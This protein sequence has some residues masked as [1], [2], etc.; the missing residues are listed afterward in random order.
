MNI[1][2]YFIEKGFLISPE[3]SDKIK[4]N[5]DNLFFLKLLKENLKEQSL[6]LNEDILTHDNLNIKNKNT[7]TLL[8]AEKEDIKKELEIKDDTEEKVIILKTYKDRAKKR[9]VQ[10]FVSY[11]RTR[12]NMLKDILIN[13]PELQNT[14]SINRIL[15]KKDRNNVAII[16]LVKEKRVTKNKNIIINVEDLSG[17]IN[18]LVNKDRRELFEIT[19]DIVLDEVI[20]VTGVNSNDIIFVNNIFFPDI[21]TNNKL[22]KIDREEYV[23]F[24]SDIHV[25]SKVFYKKN[26]LKFINW[27][28]GNDGTEEQ[29]E[30]AKK[31]K[32]LFIAGDLVE[33]VGIY[34][35]QYQYLEIPDIYQQYEEFVSLIEKINKDVQIIIIPGNH[36]AVRIAEPQPVISK[37]IAPKLHELENVTMLTNPSM[38]NIC[39]SENFPG[40]NVL[41]YHGFSFWYLG[42]NV[43]SIRTNG[44]LERAD[45]LMKFLLQRRHLAPSHTS[46][47]YIPDINQDPLIID[48]IPDFFSTGH[49]HDT[50]VINYRGVTAIGCGCWAD[51]TEYWDKRGMVPDPCKA[52]LV[53]LK[54]REIK[55]LN[56]SD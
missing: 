4:H 44:R 34:P 37:E 39:R 53:N 48:Y 51:Q 49:I 50:A 11:F 47:Q 40:F 33:G 32:Y 10:D 12:Y 14:T 21:P 8:E 25:G 13:R 6:I 30:I 27:L 54:T 56:F 22:K 42:E 3:L 1:V 36:D 24:I 16:G 46:N 17:N 55:I 20:G 45:L 26:F 9:E 43:E 41:L 31:V 15:N 35:D 23:I 28:N 19:K 18:I 7:E 38:V 2:D 29:K 52:F 5:K